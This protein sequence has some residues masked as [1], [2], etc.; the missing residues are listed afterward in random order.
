ML[1]KIFPKKAHEEEWVIDKVLPCQNH[2]FILLICSLW[3][4]I[5]YNG[6]VLRAEIA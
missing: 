2:Y 4:E 5:G 1:N 6:G 3:E